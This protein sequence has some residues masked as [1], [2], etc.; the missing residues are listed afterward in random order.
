MSVYLEV[1]DI[2]IYNRKC[3]PNDGSYVKKTKVNTQERGK[4]MRGVMPLLEEKGRFRN[5][6]IIFSQETEFLKGL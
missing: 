1:R 5:V 2:C 3:V 4:R 6:S